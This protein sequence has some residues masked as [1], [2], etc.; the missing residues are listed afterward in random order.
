M[1]RSRCEHFRA[2]CDSGMRDALDTEAAVPEEFTKVLSQR[3]DMYSQGN[4]VCSSM[5]YALH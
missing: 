5:K 2:R 3:S 1:L 4:A